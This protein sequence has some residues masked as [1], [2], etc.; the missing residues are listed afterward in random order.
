MHIPKGGTTG[1]SQVITINP[2]RRDDDDN[3]Y[4]DE[5]KFA[6]VAENFSR[7]KVKVASQFL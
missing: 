3:D 6:T 5:E 2:A 7:S 4:D 1:V